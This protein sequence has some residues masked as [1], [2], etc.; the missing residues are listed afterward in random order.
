MI[1]YCKENLIIRSMEKRDIDKLVNGFKEQNWNKPFE[2]F[3]NYYNEQKN[4]EK[5]VIIAE[6]NNNIAGYVNLLPSAKDGP[7]AYKNIPEIVDFN[8]LIKYQKKGYR[9]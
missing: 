9:Q 4:N 5:L 8:V 6:I 3:N 2:L 1:Y 7:F